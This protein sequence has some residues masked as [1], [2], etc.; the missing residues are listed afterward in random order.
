MKTNKTLLS[1]GTGIVPSF[2]IQHRLHIS[3]KLTRLSRQAFAEEIGI[4]VNTVANVE[5]GNSQPS[6]RVLYPWSRRTGVDLQWLETGVASSLSSNSGD[7]STA[8]KH[9]IVQ[10]IDSI[11]ARKSGHQFQSTELGMV[12][13]REVSWGDGL[14]VAAYK[15]GGLKSAVNRIQAQLGTTIGSPSTFSRLF[16]ADSPEELSECNLWRAWLLLVSLGEDPLN[17]GI[18]DSCVPAAMNVEHLKSAL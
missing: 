17:W 1:Q 6:H 16:H 15:D 3:R 2:G 9:Q 14:V 4:S 7:G 10:N 11:P 18:S 8:G 12:M 5:N 13:K